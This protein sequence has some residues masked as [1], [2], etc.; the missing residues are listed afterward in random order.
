VAKA[1]G[2]FVV[3]NIIPELVARVEAVSR[4]APK[5]VA[6]RVAAAA[7]SYAPVQTGFLRSS[8][9]SVSI[10]AGKSA[11]VQ[12]GADYAA[13]VEYGTY[14]MAARPFLTP[15]FEDHAKEL[16]LEIMAVLGV[17]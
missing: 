2:F 17:K 9:E 1:A 4:A 15:A 5:R 3:Y 10:E 8:I 12:V 16:G 6:D 14:K 7:R 13:Y 11:E